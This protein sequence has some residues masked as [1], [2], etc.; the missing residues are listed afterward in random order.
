[1]RGEVLMVCRYRG[2]REKNVQV[3]E[4]E[5]VQVDLNS[6]LGRQDEMTGVSERERRGRIGKG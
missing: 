5:E 6:G 3:D 2:N 1:M 4:G